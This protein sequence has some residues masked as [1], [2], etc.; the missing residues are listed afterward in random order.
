ME[1]N[2][3]QKSGMKR[4]REQCHGPGRGAETQHASSG[5]RAPAVIPECFG[6][7]EASGIDHCHSDCLLQA[8]SRSWQG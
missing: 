8:G 3:G 2:A 4:A 1:F 7:P 5:V 6:K